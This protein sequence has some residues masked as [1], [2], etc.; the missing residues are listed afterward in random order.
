V[1]E[2]AAHNVITFHRDPDNVYRLASYCAAGAGCWST[3]TGSKTAKTETIEIALA[4]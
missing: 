1:D 4:R 2:R 3:G